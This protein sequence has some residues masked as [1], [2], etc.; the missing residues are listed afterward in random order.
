MITLSNGYQLPEPGDLGDLWFQA[1][2]DNIA[3]INSHKHSGT[4]SE[5]IDASGILAI[6]DTID[7]A[8]FG[9]IDGKYR[10]L[11]TVPVGFDTATAKISFKNPTT[12]TA[13]HLEIEVLSPTTF[14]T[15]TMIPLDVEVVYG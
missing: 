4:D 11:T 7:T 14:Y 12:K 9:I 6:T 10:Y 15:V 1:L 5:K 2:E 8:D 13:V 3:L